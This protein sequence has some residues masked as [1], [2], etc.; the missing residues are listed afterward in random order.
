MRLH[1]D[2]VYVVLIYSKY[3]DLERS[4]RISRAG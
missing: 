4:N 2:Y 1:F 3:V